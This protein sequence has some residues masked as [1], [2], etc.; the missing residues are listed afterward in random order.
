MKN[1]RGQLKFEKLENRTNHMRVEEL[2][3]WVINLGENTQDVASMQALMKT[4]DIK[5][6]RY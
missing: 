5:I 3:Q 4:K 1:L 2:E 6:H